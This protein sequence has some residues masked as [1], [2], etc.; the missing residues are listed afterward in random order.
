MAPK[1]YRNG[2]SFF[3]GW[4]ATAGWIALAA[5]AAA[6]GA[7]FVT[8]IIT[9]WHPE[10]EMKTW[11][12]FLIYV[13]IV[14]QGFFLNIFSV[15]ALPVI[16]RFA[17]LWSMCGIAVVSIVCLVCARGNYQPPK[18]VF[19]SWTN[20][21]GWPDGMAFILGLLQ[22]VFGL[23]GFDA[24]THMIEES[25]CNN[26]IHP[27]LSAQ[28]CQQRA[29]GHGQCRRHGLG[30]VLDLHDRAPLLPYELYRCA[31]VG[32]HRPPSDHLLSSHPQQGRCDLPHHV[33]PHGIRVCPAGAHHHCLAHA[34]L[35]C[36]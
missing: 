2:L 17:G 19:A 34:P 7:G 4:I 25:E 35:H 10:Y 12:Q 29:Q 5:T 31:R 36:P 26:Q 1:R 24:A 13:G 23:T 18:E 32:R 8:G 20:E 16:D 9:L 27:D 15:R 33:Q 28:P 11:H 30:H 6:L 21:T 3:T 22:S 14:A